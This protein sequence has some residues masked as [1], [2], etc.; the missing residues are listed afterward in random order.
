MKKNRINIKLSTTI[1]III[2]VSLITVISLIGVGY[3]KIILLK[4]NINNMYENDVK[5]ID[6]SR[7]ITAQMNNIH[8]DVKSQ[9]IN[10]NES[11]DVV[12]DSNMDTLD[13][14]INSYREMVYDAS[15]KESIDDLLDILKSYNELWKKMDNDLLSNTEISSQDKSLLSI[16][17]K[18]AM[19]KLGKVVNNNKFDAQKKYFVSQLA[20]QKAGRDF[21]IIGVSASVVLILIS[22][23]MILYIKNSLKN[24]VNSMDIMSSGK[25]NIKIDVN[26]KNEFG[27][28]NKAL[29]KTMKS[30]SNI[31]NKIMN[32]TDNIIAESKELDSVAKGMLSASKEVS[33]AAKVMVSGSI[34]QA[35]DLMSI[36]KQFNEFSNMLNNMID[37]V[38]QMTDS[39]KDIH[40]LTN[41][42]EEGIN[43]LVESSKKVSKSFIGFKEEFQIFTELITN[44]NDIVTVITGLASQT[45]LLSLNASIEA[46]R[47]GEHG[48]GFS[49]VADEVNKLSEESRISAEKITKLIEKITHITENILSVTEEMG[50]ELN[51][52][53]NNTDNITFSLTNI[54]ENVEQSSLKIDMLS[55]SANVILKEKDNLVKRVVNASNIAEEISASVNQVAAS[56][57]QMD[58]HAKKVVHSSKN[59][60]N[61]VDETSV[62][63]NKFELC[64][65]GDSYENK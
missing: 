58:D 2:V 6:L 3:Q 52:Q 59:L 30:V 8:T 21:I 42:G 5:R 49:V 19:D 28:M 24:I 20:A 31:V 11:L 1:T 54:I 33:N 13:Q 65:E 55:N 29:D 25:L 39:N 64:E 34:S 44:V 48:K 35:Q 47:A 18:M 56:A 43:T 16:K 45:K 10:H 22:L 53:Q 23:I 60:N 57:T 17:E 46:A 50:N 14:S 62:E 12:I 9:L 51:I 7:S 61:I 37:T 27:I 26:K 36:H 38:N 4:N 15:D 41:S 40:R 63:L 32:K